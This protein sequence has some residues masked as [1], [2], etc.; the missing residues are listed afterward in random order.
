MKQL[1]KAGIQTKGLKAEPLS[2]DEEELLWQ[3]GILGDHS[4]DTAK[5]SL[6]S[7]RYLLLP[8]EVVPNIKLSDMSKTAGSLQ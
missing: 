6:S 4:T 5:H 8:S 1:R 2:L 3:K 7:N